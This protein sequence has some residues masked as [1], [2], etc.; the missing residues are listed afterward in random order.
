MRAEPSKQR[1]QCE[2]A[3][4]LPSRFRGQQM[5]EQSQACLNY[6]EA[7]SEIGHT[8]S[9][10][11]EF[12]IMR[13]KW[14]L[15]IMLTIACTATHAQQNTCTVRGRVVDADDSPVMYASVCLLADGKVAA[16]ALTD[17]TGVFLIKCT[18]GGE[19]GLKVSS[20]GYEDAIKTI[21][22]PKGQLTDVG[23]I[24]L[25]QK[26]TQLEDIVVSGRAAAKSITLEKTSINPAAMMSAATGSVLDVLRGL[27]SVS[28][29]NSGQVSIRGNG[30][31]LFLVDGVPTTLDGLGSIPTANVQSI[32]IVSSP[33]AKYDS[34][35][36]GGIISIV[37]KKQAPEAFTAMASANY[38][39]DNFMNGNL[40]MSYNVGRWGI[41]MNYN[42]K[43][44]KDHI[45]SELQ[46]HILQTYSDLEQLIDA[47]KKTTVHNIG[48]NL[49]FKA[50]TRD[51]LTIDTKVG[52][53]RMNNLQTM[54]NHYITAGSVSDKLR[55]T[56]ITFNREMVESSLSYRHI[57]D[58]GKR[59]VS[60][61]LS[62]SAINGHRPSYYYES[63]GVATSFQ[64][65]QR[66]KSGGRPRIAA[67]QIDYMTS[68]GKGKLETGMKM[69][70]RNNNIDHK[71]YEY[72]A[73]SDSWLLSIP[74]SNNL[75]HREY[76]PAAYA[77]FSS[78]FSDKLSYKAGLRLEYSRVT[79][80]SDK[81]H[82]DEASNCFFVAPNFMLN[83]RVSKPWL[84]S[85]GLSRRIS[86][87]TYPQLNPYINLIDKQTY[88]TGN[89]RLEPEKV[90]KLDM[91]Y[92]YTGQTLKVSGNAY[93][94]YS[95]DYI[96]Q[97]T[98]LDQNILVMSYVNSDM[99]L[100]T[101][102]EHNIRWN[103]LRWL[104]IDLGSNIFYAKS[105]ADRQGTS[106]RN[107]G[108]TTNNSVTLN[109]IPMKGMT[110]QAQ[111]FVTTPQYFPQFTT[112]TIHYCN[113]GVR[114]QLRK[115][116]LMFSA[117][118]TDVF[119]TRKWDISSD[120][121]VYTLVNTS[122]SRSRVLWLGVSWNFHSFKSV[123]GQ[124][125]P[126]EDRSIIR[127]GE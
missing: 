71:M 102:I 121:P 126:E 29:D 50:T 87:P 114:Q 34:E 48:L 98:Y 94:N 78:K 108:W 9:N 41:R 28:V 77:M 39:I 69:T 10:F 96:N 63:A 75:R 89:V 37:S 8:N 61:I 95:Q 47:A 116:G 20:I 30:N 90:N 118:L 84:L 112:K 64:Q 26:A 120:N 45:E 93:L 27:S 97:I 127:L 66:S 68:L 5:S 81:D 85:F 60:T 74:L 13:N 38:G 24:V 55:Q 21:H 14:I 122:K 1:E 123:S 79:L 42:G 82:L 36:T 67:F 107:Q 62:L 106:F 54:Q 72:D 125:K 33:D 73:P 19:Y 109:V 43:L 111:Y 59:E 32:D 11:S 22:I 105:R 100:K 2:L 103:A 86:R 35:G 31:V 91:G 88:E 49:N 40:A 25:S 119:N 99:D 52:F 56:D 115:T 101:G 92:T 6:A 70:Y 57:F 15:F 53:P 46:R 12:E 83:Y 76:I 124:K 113:L 58:P 110:I 51:I 4:I 65:V 7:K 3:Q 23:R 16:G 18:F 44:E 80:Q 117:L 104:D 17:T